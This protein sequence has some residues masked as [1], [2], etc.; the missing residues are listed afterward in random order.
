MNTPTCLMSELPGSRACGLF[1][2]R[3]I[4]GHSQA[5]KSFRKGLNT[6]RQKLIYFSLFR[7][8]ETRNYPP[9]SPT[10]RAALHDTASGFRPEPPP[11]VPALAPSAPRARERTCSQNPF[12]E[13]RGRGCAISLSLHRVSLLLL[14]LCFHSNHQDSRWGPANTMSSTGIFNNLSLPLSFSFYSS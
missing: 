5:M 7:A 10:P 14:P 3:A 6:R 12:M 11:I 9:V 1:N 2:I 8:A 4:T 13:N